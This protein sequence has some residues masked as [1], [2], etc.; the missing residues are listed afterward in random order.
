MKKFYSY[1]LVF[2]KGIGM[3]AAD[4]IPGVSGGT[5]A[6]LTGIYTE[7]IDSIKSINITAI[8]LLFSGRIKAFWKHVNGT[9]LASVALG[10]CIS[11]LSLA[12]LMTY[13][14]EYHLIAL[15]SF[16][17]GLI[18]SSAILILRDIKSWTLGNY[19]FLILGIGIGAIICL[20]SPSDTPNDLWF[21]FICGA[22]AICA[23]ILPGISGSFILLLF[24]KYEYMV[25]ALNSLNLPVIAVFCMGAL[26]GIISFSHVLSWLL[27]KYYSLV[28]CL[29]SGFMIGSLIKVWPWQDILESGI[30]RP[31]MPDANIF[32][33]LVFALIGASI[34][35]IIEFAASKIK[36]LK[37]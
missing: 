1:L 31:V 26:V 7:L 23:M 27:K 36:S 2:I 14:M 6:L 3:G 21:I 8:K 13:L 12:K 4:V 25:G 10:V 32:Q 33:A 20:L 17:F 24:G 35:L 37:S 11:L 18:I 34:I 9:F 5:I 30:S 19:I 16:F 29:L 22:I 28:I 15:W